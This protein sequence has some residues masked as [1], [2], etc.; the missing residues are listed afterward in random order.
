MLSTAELREVARGLAPFVI[1]ELRALAQPSNDLVRGT[2]AIAQF[3]NVSDQ[4]VRNRKF[5]PHDKFKP[6]DR[7]I[8]IRGTEPYTRKVRGEK[9]NFLRPVAHRA[10]LTRYIENLPS[11]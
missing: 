4:T 9:K 10:D 6:G 11:K 7:R 8:P 5:V 3:L 1:E 2:E